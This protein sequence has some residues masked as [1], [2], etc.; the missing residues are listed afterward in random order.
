MLVD[1]DRDKATS[2]EG[3]EWRRE[4]NYEPDYYKYISELCVLDAAIHTRLAR[5]Y[6]KGISRELYGILVLSADWPP[7]ELKYGNRS[8]DLRIPESAFET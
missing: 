5:A 6:S 3:L 4:R 1:G 7:L 8:P 2:S